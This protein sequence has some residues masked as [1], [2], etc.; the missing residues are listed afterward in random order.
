[1]K[2]W[3]WILCL[4]LAAATD[5]YAQAGRFKQ[6]LL[7]ADG[8]TNDV[9][10]SAV[11][12]DGNWAVLGAP[13]QAA[14]NGS[15]YFFQWDGTNW[16]QQAE[17]V[18]GDSAVGDNFGEAVAISGDA[19]IVGATRPIFPDF[20][21]QAYVFTRSG[22][23]WN[24]Q[25]GPLTGGGPFEQFGETVDIDGD[26][27]IVG[28]RLAANGGGTATGAAYVFRRTGGTWALEDT[29]FAADG[30]DGDWFGRDVA[31]HGD[32]AIVGANARS[33]FTGGAYVFQRSG[34]TWS[35]VAVLENPDGETNDLFGGAVDLGGDWAVVGTR[36]DEFQG[37][38]LYRRDATLGWM[39][40]GGLPDVYG[41]GD[42]YG[43][44]VA[45]E[46][47]Y[48]VV[49]G[50]AHAILWKRGEEDWTKQIYLGGSGDDW[51]LAGTRLAVHWRNV[52]AGHGGD[53]ELG[54]N[55]GAGWMLPVQDRNRQSELMPTNNGLHLFGSGIAV[56]GDRALVGAEGGNV[57]QDFG[58][59][60]VFARTDEYWLAQTQ[61][62]PADVADNM[63]FGSA[64]A[65]AG[66]YA[67]VGARRATNAAG[68]VRGA[69]YAFWFDGTDWVQ[70]AKLVDP[71]GQDGEEFGHAVETDGT[72]ALVGAPE[73]NGSDGRVVA[74]RRTGATWDEIGTLPGPGLD[75]AHFGWDLGFDGT[76]A[77]IGSPGEYVG[78]L[79]EAGAAYVYRLDG[80]WNLEARLTAAAPVTLAGLGTA[81]DLDD[82]WAVCGAPR[83][84][85]PVAQCGAIYLFR[86]SGT[87]W[88]QHLR[89]P[90]PEAFTNGYFGASVALRKP[91]LL[92]C[93]NGTDARRAYLYEQDGTNW[94]LLTRFHPGDGDPNE[95]FGSTCDLSADHAAIGL[96]VQD[97]RKGYL[98]WREAWDP[99]PIFRNLE[100]EGGNTIRLNLSSLPIGATVSVQRTP[101][102]SLPEPTNWNEIVVIRGLHP[103]TNW[104]W[105]ITNGP[106]EVIRMVTYPEGPATQ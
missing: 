27:A 20:T 21:G 103:G 61:L 70:Q 52:L 48:A 29:L 94:N 37:A 64:A 35:Q 12:V 24:Q 67:L 22:T 96:D 91:Y 58:Y 97:A 68:S 44:D 19:A 105:I 79:M 99:Q 50:G 85:A 5:G 66:D 17:V 62:A 28:A 53:D 41:R 47:P 42:F 69:A 40:H 36:H 55:A 82:D 86:R 34:A 49:G 45:L 71:A 2:A 11:D 18:A 9:F 25:G 95:S 15:A 57:A 23:N 87:N 74:F 76:R 93:A 89:I 59:C 100:L 101:C 104:N 75:T 4:G 13:K 80:G 51:D 73:F 26:Q 31:I 88:T 54:E 16:E 72:V 14:T 81:V 92:A 60:G 38:Y 90:A 32:H 56:D 10:A 39:L 43:Q 106:C 30:S 6:K 84:D 3:R 77:V 8:T 46:D 78:A 63:L 102:N 33:N 83:E 1:M 98:F 65:L 7:A